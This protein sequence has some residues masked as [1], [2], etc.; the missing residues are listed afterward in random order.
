M[1]APAQGQDQE[2]N[3]ILTEGPRLTVVRE[4]DISGWKV[5]S[6]TGSVALIQF[7][8]RNDED[9]FAVHVTDWD[10]Y[11]IKT[12]WLYFGRTTL[13]FESDDN[14]QRNFE[15]PVSDLKK[16][17]GQ[18]NYMGWNYLVI[19][20]RGKEKR[21]MINF[22][23]VPQSRTGPWGAH[24]KP[25]FDLLQRLIASYDEVAREFQERLTQLNKK[26]GTTTPTSSEQESGPATPTVIVNIE[27]SSEPSGAEIYVDGVF[28]S[29]TP[30]KL[31]LPIGERAIRVSRAGFKDWERK[32]VVD[33]TS[34][35]T[36]NAILEKI[37]SP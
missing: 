33:A 31:S 16:V 9:V 15:A 17:K 30:S 29:S 36:L 5:T 34:S 7:R 27:I 26:S 13:S 3:S 18:K 8:K 21:F 10:T 19:K 6:R 28:S 22:D 32:V 24:Q 2:D 4:N 1:V 37:G 23:P 20:V 12:G 25:V 14:K 35:K 11:H